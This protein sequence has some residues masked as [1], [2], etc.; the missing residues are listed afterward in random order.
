MLHSP[1]DGCSAPVSLVQARNICWEENWV[2]F[3]SPPGRQMP[4]FISM[5]S[6]CFLDVRLYPGSF[7]LMSI[8]YLSVTKWVSY[9]VGPTRTGWFL[10]ALPPILPWPRCDTPLLSPPGYITNFGS[11]GE[12]KF[13][14]HQMRT[15]PG[16]YLIFIPVLRWCY[17][18]SPLISG[19]L[20]TVQWKI[21]LLNNGDNLYS[22]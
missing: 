13:I 12:M 22:G 3:L 20:Q 15:K 17:K 5:R 11:A 14:G 18:I 21:W 19:T 10:Q 8:T 6:G 9:T 4:D 16:K 2:L 7:L 1:P